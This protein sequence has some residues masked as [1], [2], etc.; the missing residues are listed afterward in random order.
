MGGRLAECIGSVMTG[1]AA[2]RYGR[3]NG[4]SGVIERSGRPRG[5]RTMTD[6]ALPAGRNMRG[7][8]RLGVLRKK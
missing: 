3:T 4:C 1:R 5:G 6:I 7:R 2:T 8:L